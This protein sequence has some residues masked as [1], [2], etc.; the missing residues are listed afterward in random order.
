MI[1]RPYEIRK[2]LQTLIKTASTRTYFEDV[3][4]NATYPYA[5]F[6]LPVS[7]DFGEGFEVYTMDIDFWDKSTDTTALENLANNTHKAIN[8]VITN[9]IDGSESVSFRALLENRRNLNDPDKRLKR[10]QYTYYI[11]IIGR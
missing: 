9:Y 8:N 3:P 1:N 5:V 2:A 4:E 10:R 7:N 6:N 11:R